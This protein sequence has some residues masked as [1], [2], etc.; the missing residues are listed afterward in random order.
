MLALGLRLA[1]SDVETLAL[2]EA[3]GDSEDEGLVLADG[4]S[5]LEALLEADAEAEREAL[6]EALAL[7]ERLADGLWEALG[8]KLAEGDKLADGLTLGETEGLTLGEGGNG[9][10]VLNVGLPLPVRSLLLEVKSVN[11]SPSKPQYP[12]SPASFPAR[13]LYLSSC[14][15]EAVLTSFQSLTSSSNPSN[16][17]PPSLA[18]IWTSAEALFIEAM[19]VLP[20]TSS[21]LPRLI[22]FLK[23]SKVD[24]EGLPTLTVTA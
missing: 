17:L 18:P 6:L 9:T 13:V 2:V 24:A 5:D 7:G 21:P 20:P 10:S 15:S 16:V 12:T 22:P 23:N 4:D 3:E 1:L 19:L 8:L 11:T 14:I